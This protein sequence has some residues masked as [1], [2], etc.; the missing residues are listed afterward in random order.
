M[1]YMIAMAE[2]ASIRL[3]IPSLTLTTE[4]D[5]VTHR[6]RL[7]RCRCFDPHCFRLIRRLEAIAAPLDSL[8]DFDGPVELVTLGFKDL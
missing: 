6:L 5:D 4:A 7:G 2:S 8:Q 1:A 3:H